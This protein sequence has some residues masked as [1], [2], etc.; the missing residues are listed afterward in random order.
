MVTWR[1]PNPSKAIRVLCGPT[2][3]IH[4]WMTRQINFDGKLKL[5]LLS[6]IVMVVL[7]RSKQFLSKINATLVDSLIRSTF[8]AWT[9]HCHSL[10]LRQLL[11]IFTCSYLTFNINSLTPIIIFSLWFKL[12]AKSNLHF[13]C[14]LSDKR[15]EIL[16]SR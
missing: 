8:L 10:T 6:A 16:K 2:F 12:S 11:S 13:T 9:C 4:G 1:I 3:Q 7:R 5:H 15:L 14:S